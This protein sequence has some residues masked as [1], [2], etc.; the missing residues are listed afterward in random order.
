MSHLSSA[1]VRYTACALGVFSAGLA[2]AGCASSAAAPSETPA[3]S[4][5]VLGTWAE[6]QS[7]HPANIEI[8]DGNQFVAFDG[9]NTL[10]GTWQQ[11]GETVAFETISTTEM[12]CSDEAWL[13]GLATG[14]IAGTEMTILD[15]EDHELGRLIRDK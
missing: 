6:A 15:A 9:C 5:A 2:L 14:H 10:N 11:D 4:V 1:I 12:A 7:A 3:E 13:T 8:K